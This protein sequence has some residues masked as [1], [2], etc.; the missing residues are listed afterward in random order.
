MAPSKTLILTT[1]TLSPS[2]FWVSRYFLMYIIEE[3]EDSE[4]LRGSN[5]F[6]EEIIIIMIFKNVILNM[7][8]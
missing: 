8:D 7:I 6:Q 3:Y 4:N 1:F 2:D 5:V